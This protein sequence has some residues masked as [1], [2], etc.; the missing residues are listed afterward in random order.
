MVM[1]RAQSSAGYGALPAGYALMLR[2]STGDIQLFKL[3]GGTPTLLV[4]AT[5]TLMQTQAIFV[6]LTSQG[7][8]LTFDYSAEGYIWNTRTAT[9]SDFTTGDAAICHWDTSVPLGGYFDDV[10]IEEF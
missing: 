5:F 1:L 6:R 2:P 4:G 10:V 7:S 9:D 8:S 3:K